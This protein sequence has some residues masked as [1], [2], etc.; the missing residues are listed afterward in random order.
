MKTKQFVS[1]LKLLLPDIANTTCTRNCCAHGRVLGLQAVMVLAIM[2][3][4]ASLTYAQAIGAQAVVRTSE[5]ESTKSAVER[6]LI[7][8]IDHGDVHQRPGGSPLSNRLVGAIAAAL[9]QVVVTGAC[10][11]RESVA[12]LNVTISSR[13]KSDFEGDG[14]TDI[15]L[16]H[17]DGRIAYLLTKGTKFPRL[18]HSPY[19]TPPGFEVVGTG[20]FDR[21]G[22]P[23]L[24]L[25]RA[26]GSIA[27]WLMTGILV[28]EEVQGEELPAG[29]QIAGVADLDSD[30]QP[31]LALR[32][33]DGIIA[34]WLMDGTDIRD[35]IFF[36]T[37]P[38]RWR[39]AAIGEFNGDSQADI[40][41]QH[42][43][44]SV[45]LLLMEK[46]RIAHSSVLSRAASAWKI[47]GTGDFDGDA[48]TDIV[49]QHTD[50]SVAF[51]LLNG[52]TR[53][54]SLV[55]YKIHDPDWQIVASR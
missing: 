3:P 24:V 29:W 8:S 42:E 12:L 27:F 26:D 44:G 45:A 33:E 17:A 16:Q 51:W 18:V 34:F 32:H 25:H 31:D 35:S 41:L 30:G 13:P 28:R 46:M 53:K 36:Y 43:N 15:V 7:E 11:T 55:A 37:L 39:V 6:Q 21:D 1:T 52:T 10:E 22:L 4:S 19:S 48:Q 14:E 20:D 2:L 54:K 47:A 38:V 23:D 49:L 9:A 50:G 5:G 40:V